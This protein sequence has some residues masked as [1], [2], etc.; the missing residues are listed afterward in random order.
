MN[1]DNLSNFS[2][3]ANRKMILSGRISEM[4][5]VTTENTDSLRQLEMC[6]CIILTTESGA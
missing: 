3:C 6:D 2:N 1:D 5:D 4:C